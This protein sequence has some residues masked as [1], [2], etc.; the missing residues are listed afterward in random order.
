MCFF[1]TF[2]LLIL[3]NYLVYFESKLWIVSGAQKGRTTKEF[4]KGPQLKG[5]PI[6]SKVYIIHQL[7]TIPECRILPFLGPQ[8]SKFS[9]GIP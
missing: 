6:L 9:R 2:M 4:A 5:A 7:K 1:F 3:R 8:I